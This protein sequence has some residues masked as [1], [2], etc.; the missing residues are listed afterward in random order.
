MYA[1]ALSPHPCGSVHSASSA[2]GLH[3]SRVLRCLSHLRLKITN[4]SQADQR[5]MQIK[6]F[7]AEAGPTVEVA[8]DSFRMHAMLLVGPALAGKRPV[9]ALTFDPGLNARWEFAVKHH[10]CGSPVSKTARAHAGRFPAKASPTNSQSRVHS[11]GLAPTVGP[12]SAGKPLI[13]L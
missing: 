10:P 8:A 4:R 13:C 6:G 9:Q 2:F 1:M 3:P 12:A 11:V 7:P 5:Q